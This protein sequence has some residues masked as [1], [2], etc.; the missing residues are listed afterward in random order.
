VIVRLLPGGRALVDREALAMETGLAEVTIRTRLSGP[1]AYDYRTGRALYDHDTA[2]SALAT[3]R[4]WSARRG[5]L[6]GVGRT[7][8]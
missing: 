1:T 7:S 8:V 5:L 2:R 3:V 4:P 6:H